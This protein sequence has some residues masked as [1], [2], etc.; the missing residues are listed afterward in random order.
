M[1]TGCVAGAAVAT[2]AGPWALAYLGF[3]KA[4]VVAGSL[5][6]TYQSGHGAIVAGS[7]FSLCQSAGA[8]GV[9]AVKTKMIASGVGAA[10]AAFTRRRV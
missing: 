1:A 10:F 6:A 9:L 4:G 3:T 5:A 7:V 2:V 8:T